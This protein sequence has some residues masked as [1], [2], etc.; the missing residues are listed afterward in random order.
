[1]KLEEQEKCRKEVQE[2]RRDMERTHQLR[3]EALINREKNA[4]ERLQKQQEVLLAGAW[5]YAVIILGVLLL[6]GRKPAKSASTGSHI[7]L[8]LNQILSHT[9]VSNTGT[10]YIEQQDGNCQYSRPPR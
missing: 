3:S 9:A 2:L 8:S 4:I 7:L 5:H 6:K 10:F 1:M